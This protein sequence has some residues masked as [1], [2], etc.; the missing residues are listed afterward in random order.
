MRYIC[1]V[2]GATSVSAA[3]METLKDTACLEVGCDGRVVLV[4][5]DQESDSAFAENVLEFLGANAFDCAGMP[6]PK[7]ENLHD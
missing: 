3:T 6:E 5:D 1:T 4:P 2:C 7:E